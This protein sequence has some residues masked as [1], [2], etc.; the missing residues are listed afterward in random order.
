MNIIFYKIYRKTINCSLLIK[1][2]VAEIY[3]KNLYQNEKRKK[4]F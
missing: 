3:L 4:N 1:E 2:V